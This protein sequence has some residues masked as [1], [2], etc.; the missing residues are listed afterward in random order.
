LGFFIVF[1][2]HS[3]RNTDWWGHRPR[4]QQQLGLAANSIRQV[5]TDE[6]QKDE[7]L[8]VT[9]PQSSTEEFNGRNCCSLSAVEDRTLLRN[10]M[11]VLAL[12]PSP[13]SS[14]DFQGKSLHK[15]NEAYNRY[16]LQDS[17]L[18]R[19]DFSSQNNIALLLPISVC[20]PGQRRALQQSE[21]YS[22]EY[23]CRDSPGKRGWFY[24]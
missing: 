13:P 10:N 17:A 12:I 22:K 1:S 6:F 9:I 8:L 16:K 21:L 11:R 18:T 14:K 5:A 4:R 19:D 15:F 24:D 23:L 2:F 20:L 3:I 7:N